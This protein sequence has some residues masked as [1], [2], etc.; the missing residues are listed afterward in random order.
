MNYRFD[1]AAV[2]AQWPLLLQ[3]AWVTI[4]LSFF[5]TVAGL[6]LGTA[7][8]LGRRSPRPWLS[9]LVGAYVE[10]IRNTPLLIQSYFLIFGLSSIGLTMPI[11]VGATLA[12]VINIGA[13]TCEI[14]RAGIESIHRGQLEAAE[15]LAL[16][17]AQVFFHVVLRPALERVYP[18]L[19]SQF[20][21][22]MLAS[23]IMSAVG[24]DEL[25]GMANRIQSDT[26]RNFEVFLVLWGVYLLL[27]YLMRAGFWVLG[28]IVFTRRRRLGTP[29]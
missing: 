8:A 19:T 21:L 1:F 9:G 18:S 11:M 3:G 26:F 22:L 27:S 16:T 13:Y 14:V 28:Q 17:K 25:L 15:C 20:A 24:A 29:L 4:Q 5:S 23:S 2:L 7:C 10:L 12:M 6:V